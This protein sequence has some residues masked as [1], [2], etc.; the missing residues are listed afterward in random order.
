M[1][2]LVSYMVTAHAFWLSHSSHIALA[3]QGQLAVTQLGSPFA[4]FFTSSGKFPVLPFLS[5]I[6]RTL[7]HALSDTSSHMH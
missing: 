3:I 6:Y 5:S 1:R 7:Y 2:H 4:Y